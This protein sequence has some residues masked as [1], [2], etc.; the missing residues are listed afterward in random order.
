[1]A[2]SLAQR[3]ALA[4]VPKFTGWISFGFS[5]L[6]AAAVLRDKN[7]RSLCYHRLICGISLVDMSASLWLGMSTWPIPRTSA[8]LWAMGNVTSCNVQG[9]F[10]QFGISSSFYNASLA[11][12]FYLVIVRGWNEKL[13]QRIEW[14][15]HTIP[16]L[17]ASV[18]AVTGLFLHVYDD[19]TL[20]CWVS[21]EKVSFRWIAFYGPLWLNILIVTCS[22]W[23][24]FLHVRKLELASQKHRLFVHE[25]SITQQQRAGEASAENG[26]R[27]AQ[28]CD[29]HHRDC[30]SSAVRQCMGRR[31]NSQSF[32]RSNSICHQS[33]R[34]KDVADQ[35]F[36]F[37]TAFYVNWAALTV[38]EQQNMVLYW[39]QHRSS[40]NCSKCLTIYFL[41]STRR[42]VSFKP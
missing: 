23:A 34:V 38:C 20:W 26:K 21:A 2:L 36:L 24:I 10:T 8:S 6:V 17:W 39:N 18:S 29:N 33:R 3:R 5:G 42:L 31:Q 19:A 4:L 30:A 25:K 12:Y 16:L 27:P 35:C 40:S 11:I 14:I 32:R 7:R 22:C 1:M 15:L 37:A 13:L 41:S 9:F 28:N